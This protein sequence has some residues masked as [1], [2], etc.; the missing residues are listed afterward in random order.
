MALLGMSCIFPVPDI[1]QTADYYEKILGFRAVSYLESQEPHICLYR[2]DSELILLQA[3]GEQV[4]PNRTLYGYGYD[5][6]LYAQDLESLQRELQ[7]AGAKIIRSLNL[8]DYRN[9]ELVVEDCDGRWLA[10]GLKQKTEEQLH[11]A[12]SGF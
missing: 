11:A 4:F 12:A 9:Q 3:E 8:T 2:D 10:F 6:Y 1:R 5:A 7:Q